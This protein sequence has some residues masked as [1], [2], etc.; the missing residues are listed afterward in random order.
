MS[1][2]DPEVTK[3]QL[4]ETHS[5]SKYSSEAQTSK[6]IRTKESCL[7]VNI[8]LLVVKFALQEEWQQGLHV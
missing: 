5:G 7:L 3:F 6:Y 2:D 1:I 4:L 8:M